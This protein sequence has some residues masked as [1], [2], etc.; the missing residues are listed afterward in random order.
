MTL[1]FQFVSDTN[2]NKNNYL[3]RFILQNYQGICFCALIVNS[4]DYREVI[5]KKIGVFCIFRKNK[6][7]TAIVFRQCL[8]L[9]IMFWRHVCY[10]RCNWVLLELSFL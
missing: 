4:S 1:N 2:E 8:E 9:S 3:N 5:D 7:L 10:T 6:D